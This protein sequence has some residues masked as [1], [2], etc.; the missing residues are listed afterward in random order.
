MTIIYRVTLGKYAGTTVQ[1]T[2]YIKQEFI[3]EE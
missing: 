2:V 3:V 1:D